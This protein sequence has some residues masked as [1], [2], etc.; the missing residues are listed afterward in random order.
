MA[1][2]GRRELGVPGNRPQ[3]VT[4]WSRFPFKDSVPKLDLPGV[5]IGL[6]DAPCQSW[7]I[8]GVRR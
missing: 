8:Y 3:W 2:Q 7:A 4:I 6:K 1:A 5:T